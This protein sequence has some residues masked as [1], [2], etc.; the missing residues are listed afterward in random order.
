MPESNAYEIADGIWMIDALM[1]GEAEHLSTYVIP[2]P[3]PTLIDPGPTT[4]QR[5]ILAGLQAIG[6]G[7]VAQIICTHI[8]LDHAGGA[9]SL[10]TQFRNA[11]VLV[12]DYGAEHLIDPAKLIRS[13]SRIYGE[14]RMAALWGPIVPVD[15]AR[16]RSVC[17]GDTIA[18]GAGRTLEVMYTP[19]HA[20]HHMSLADSETGI[21]MVGDSAGLTFPETDVVHPVVPPPDIDVELLISQYVKYR[22]RHPPALAF[23]HFGLKSDI[24]GTL[25]ETERRLRLWTDVALC[26]R[27]KTPEQVGPL[28]R[29]ANL[30]DLHACGHPDAHVSRIDARTS[31]E[32]DAAGL[33]RYLQ[34]RKGPR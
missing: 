29:K 30:A 14:D 22:K 20:R 3:I 23:A 26:H 17:D 8:H 32:A 24:D 27:E 12:H 33:L 7:D 19:G 25:F 11:T 34:S 2:E 13:A 1:H 16:I 10:A 4:S 5:A 6:L 18:L 28:I 31:Y 9:G 15:S 21:I